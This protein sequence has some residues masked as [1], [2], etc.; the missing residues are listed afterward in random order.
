MPT[1]LTTSTA[2]EDLIEAT[3][4][5]GA[6]VVQLPRADQTVVNTS[7][8]RVAVLTARYLNTLRLN[9][10]TGEEEHDELHAAAVRLIDCGVA[11]GMRACSRAAHMDGSLMTA[12][13]ACGPATLNYLRTMERQHS[14]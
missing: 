2:R 6:L 10:D 7:A 3:I 13:D 14:L 4:S 5:L 12:A 9:P 11:V 1:A 8:G